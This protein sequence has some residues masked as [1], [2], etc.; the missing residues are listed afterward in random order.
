MWVELV[1]GMICMVG[2][3]LLCIAR[4]ALA[5]PQAFCFLREAPLYAT[6]TNYWTLGRYRR[7]AAAWPSLAA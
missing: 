4:T 1:M 7:M 3:L 6:L 2:K 5:F